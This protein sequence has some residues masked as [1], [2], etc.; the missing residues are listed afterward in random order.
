MTNA[1]FFQAMI[2][3]G[4]IV[5]G[6]LAR[7]ARAQPYE[8]GYAA[9]PVMAVAPESPLRLSDAEIDELLASIALYPD[10]LL[11]Q[12]LPASTYPLDIVLAAQWL[13]ANPDP[14]DAA[15]DRQNW[16]PSVRALA[17]YPTVIETMGE[18]AQW[19]QAVGAVFM[20][21]QADVMASIQR[22][23]RSALDVQS[24]ESTPQ[25]Q[26]VV[27]DDAVQIL[28][29]N[30]DLLYV[31]QYDP[32]IIYERRP[33]GE[34]IL[35]EG[36]GWR[37]GSWLDNDFDWDHHWVAVGGGWHEGWRFENREWRREP[38]SP[39]GINVTRFS[40]NNTNANVSVSR[41]WGRNEAKARPVL[42]PALVQSRTAAGT[43]GW[44]T[45]GSAPVTPTAI[46]PKPFAIPSP[47]SPRTET[48][49]PVTL[50]RTG[51]P[52]ATTTP[53]AAVRPTPPTVP[54]TRITPP[55]AVRTTSPTV[56]SAFD[57][58]LNGGDLGRAV[59]RGTRSIKSS[60]P[61]TPPA[62]IAAPPPTPP[63]RVTAPPPT[64]PARL[65]APP[66]AP[67]A[68]VA[69]PPVRV[70]APSP[71]HVASPPASA[72]APGTS[73]KD[74]NDASKRGRTSLGH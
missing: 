60:T 36:R 38:P 44:A 6:G 10:P 21:Q 42:P 39:A 23:R 49:P 28:P 40:R 54:S 59:D 71:A 11:A 63:A 22:L 62:R 57:P 68:R 53:P 14:D 73:S 70:A 35:F 5:I 27:Y 9:P 1:T 67:P 25:Q 43:R 58:N 65:T 12:V 20:N 3:G 48:R 55:A 7:P 56:P 37:I 2:L 64:P 41:P 33:Q 74:A 8:G 66:P 4:A 19:T 32:I 31:P 24:L 29:A 16:E 50:P 18:H 72:F 47:A 69:A 52:S 13:K 30:P 15:I 45:P 61:A 34:R 46:R 26:V 17:H 51:T